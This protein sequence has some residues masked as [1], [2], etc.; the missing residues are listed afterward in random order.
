MIGFDGSGVLTW[1]RFWHDGFLCE[2]FFKD[3]S[4]WQAIGL[5]LHLLEAIGLTMKIRFACVPYWMATWTL[6]C[7]LFIVNSLMLNKIALTGLIF[8]PLEDCIYRISSYNIKIIKIEEIKN[9]T[10][11]HLYICFIG[12]LL[13]FWD[14]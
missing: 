2:R 9:L 3:D 4:F 1:D 10:L 6:F 12:F 13:G 7:I 11:G 8:W 5:G 14:S